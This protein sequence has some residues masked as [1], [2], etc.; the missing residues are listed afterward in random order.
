MILVSSNSYYSNYSNY[1]Y[2]VTSHKVRFLYVSYI[3]FV[4]YRGT[5]AQ[6]VQKMLSF[7]KFK[8]GGF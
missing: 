4:E 7:V 1:Y 8:N 5:Q 3:L 2:R 6:I